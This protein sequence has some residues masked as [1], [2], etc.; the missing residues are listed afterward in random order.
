MSHPTK[1]IP[2]TTRENYLDPIWLRC[3]T[4]SLLGPLFA[5][6]TTH[7]KNDF[8]NFVPTILLVPLLQQTSHSKQISQ[9]TP[10]PL[11]AWE[12]IP[13]T[14]CSMGIG[15]S[16]STSLLCQFLLH[17]GILNPFLWSLLPF[18]LPDLNVQ[19]SLC[20]SLQQSLPIAYLSQNCILHGN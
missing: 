18:P 17:F 13:S 20:R 19:I 6:R 14:S 3:P 12:H 2:H 5:I 10:N 1:A 8:Y 16:L 4:Q 11:D 9:I 15:E 7:K